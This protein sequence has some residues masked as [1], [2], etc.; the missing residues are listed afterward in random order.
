MTNIDRIYNHTDIP[1]S[2][3]RSNPKPSERPLPPNSIEHGD[4]LEFSGG[5]PTSLQDY[6]AH[7]R[8]ANILHSANDHYIKGGTFSDHDMHALWSSPGFQEAAN[9]MLKEMDQKPSDE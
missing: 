9:K 1:E 3:I 5:E 6:V 8:P 4:H 7:S 2:R